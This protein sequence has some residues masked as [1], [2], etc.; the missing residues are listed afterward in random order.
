VDDARKILHDYLLLFAMVNAVGNLPVFAD[1]TAGLERAQR[2]R[3]FL[4]A[5]GTAAGIVVGFA[6][7]GHWMLD[8]VFQIQTSHFQVAGGILVFIVAAR[9]VILGPRQ[10]SIPADATAGGI[11]VFPLGFP[12]LAGP[13][14]ILTTILLMRQHGSFRTAIAALLVYATV[15]PL[16][17]LAPLVER[18]I[19]RV[20]VL[21]VSRVLY[22]FISA[23]AVSFVLSGLTS[24]LAGARS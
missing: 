3:T 23:K 21:V 13:G 4:V 8:D 22:I 14:T 17:R 20:G 19:G 1:L 24:A 12:F 18:A 2:S 15:L 11:G 10:A 7:L 5:A 6:V 9:G 16:L